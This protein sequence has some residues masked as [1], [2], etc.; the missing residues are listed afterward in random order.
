MHISCQFT[1]NFDFI[2]ELFYLRKTVCHTFIFS[3]EAENKEAD[4]M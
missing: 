2:P 4:E 1:G 3:G